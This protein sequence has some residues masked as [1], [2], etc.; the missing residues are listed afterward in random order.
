MKTRR[1]FL[2]PGEPVELINPYGTSVLK[3]TAPFDGAQACVVLYPQPDVI[4]IDSTEAK[5]FDLSNKPISV[6]TLVH[7]QAALEFNP[8]IKL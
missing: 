2:Q 7:D 3:A 6:N 1:I 8:D 4:T 5:K